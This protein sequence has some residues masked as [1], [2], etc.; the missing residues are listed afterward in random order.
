MLLLARLAWS[1]FDWKGL[2]RNPNPHDINKYSDDVTHATMTYVREHGYGHE[3]WNFDSEFCKHFEYENCEAGYYYGT[4][5]RSTGGIPTRLRTAIKKDA[6]LVILFI[7]WDP[8]DGYM[9]IIGAYV[10]AT[11][12]ADTYCK[13]NMSYKDALWKNLVSKSSINQNTKN[14]FNSIFDG[15]TI[16]FKAPKDKSFIL[17]D[18]MRIKV[19]QQEYFGTSIRQFIDVEDI[20]DTAN[21]EKIIALTS[22]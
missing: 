18:N 19:N 12:L 16:I 1:S 14:T 20:T 15:V 11:Y 9:K 10:D 3:W 7:S 13:V 21:Y 8:S 2:T 5:P 6:E 17:P 22:F 4:V